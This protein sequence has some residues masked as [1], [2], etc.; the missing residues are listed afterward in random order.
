MKSFVEGHGG[1]VRVASEVGRGTTFT[2]VL[3]L[4]PPTRGVQ[5]APPMMPEMPDR[6]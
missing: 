6:F 3:P 5:V 1:R 4:V 2:A